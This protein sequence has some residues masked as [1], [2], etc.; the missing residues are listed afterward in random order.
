MMGRYDN[1]VNCKEDLLASGYSLECS[2]EV[3]YGKLYSDTYIKGKHLNIL[4]NYGPNWC[5]MV[6]RINYSGKQESECWK[7][8]AGTI[9][10]TYEVTKSE[11]PLV[12]RDK[13]M[14]VVCRY[15]YDRLETEFRKIE[16]E[17]TLEALP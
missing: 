16:I 11:I 9:P 6:C 8:L 5:D 3:Q 7:D 2:R 12:D 10:T 4:L 15:E 1:W 14:E 13:F 17:S